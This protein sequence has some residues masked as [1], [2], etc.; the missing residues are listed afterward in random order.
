MPPTHNL[1]FNTRYWIHC[2]SNLKVSRTKIEN[3]K[4]QIMR[5]INCVTF[6]KFA[7]S[8]IQKLKILGK[9]L[10]WSQ[11][12]DLQFLLAPNI[13]RFWTNDVT[14]FPKVTQ[15]TPLLICHFRF[16]VHRF[17]KKCSQYLELNPICTTVCS[18][19]QILHRKYD[20]LLECFKYINHVIC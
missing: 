7:T 15:L 17:K 5:D 13:L 18:E 10:I 4:W 2:H 19:P 8:L 9:K 12:L 11:Y 3:L 14:I 20:N 6:E 1:R 16:S